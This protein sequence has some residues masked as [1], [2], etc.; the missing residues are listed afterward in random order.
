MKKS[1]GNT[2]K[3]QGSLNLVSDIFSCIDRTTFV[4]WQRMLDT[5]VQTTKADSVTFS[6]VGE[7]FRRVVLVSTTESMNE[8]PVFEVGELCQLGKRSCSG[9]LVYQRDS[10][11]VSDVRTS[12]KWAASVGRKRKMKSFLGERVNHKD[13]TP[14]GVLAMYAEK[15]NVFSAADLVL[16]H[17]MRH[18]IE[19]DFE[20]L[21][22][23]ATVTEQHETM[24]EQVEVLERMVKRNAGK[25]EQITEVYQ[26]DVGRLQKAQEALKRSQADYASLVQNIPGIVYHCA[27]DA[28]WTMHLISDDVEEI[29]G[30]PADDFIH[31]KVRTYAS[32]IHEEDQALVEKAVIEG[33]RAKST[34]QIE[35]RIV[36]K[37]GGVRWVF[38]QGKAVLGDDGEVLWLDGV[39]LDISDK[40]Q[41]EDKLHESEQRGEMLKEVAVAANEAAKISEVFREALRAVCQYTSWPMGHV[42]MPDKHG[43]ELRPVGLWYV[44]EGYRKQ[45]IER[46]TKDGYYPKGLGL[47]GHVWSTGEPYWCEDVEHDS[48]FIRH[49]L[50]PAIPVKSAFAMPITSQGEVVAVMEFFS[51][52]PQPRDVELLQVFDRIGHQLGI[53]LERKH[54]ELRLLDYQG[55]LE[56]RVRRRTKALEESNYQLQSSLEALKKQ[57]EI[58]NQDL[59]MA[60]Q[61]QVRFLPDDYPF[62]ESMRFAGFYNACSSVGGDL[63]DVFK[64]NERSVGFYMAD[65]SGHGVSA[66]MVTAVLKVAIDRSISI[67]RGNLNQRRP[68]SEQV[69]FREFMSEINKETLQVTEHDKF[70][71]LQLGILDIETGRLLIVNAGHNKPLIWHRSLG[72]CRPVGIPANVPVGLLPDYRFEA[73]DVQLDHG[74]K[75]VIYTD[76]LTERANEH[77]EEFGGGRL[78]K[79]VDD[80]GGSE[81]RLLLKDIMRVNAAHAHGALAE[82]DVALLVAEYL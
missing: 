13:G 56:A 31:N 2:P 54:A 64:V 49:L 25:L 3:T 22:H 10:L 66:A 23:L 75:I 80:G 58:M 26:K 30:Y 9:A 24:T 40:K 4:K 41:A 44:R 69:K 51:P 11:N 15:P 42:F 28:D 37:D 53:V 27:L 6:L 61:L 48:I 76:G 20:H 35:Y 36:R 19:G 59:E 52:E 43:G 14:A 77:G 33:V 70:V 78:Q 1:I 50:N 60:K 46:V 38:E 16:L 7:G 5:I 73:V 45:E 12:N 57:E 29:T 82:D 47:P 74:D 65:V 39:I 32:V 21:Q 18:C 55:L 79:V 68:L 17:Q 72:K 34:Y 63:Y 8:D 62:A 67:L 71:T 81:P